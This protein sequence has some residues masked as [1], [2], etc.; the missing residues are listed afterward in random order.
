MSASWKTAGI[1][2]GVAVASGALFLWLGA[3]LERFINRVERVSH[4][5]PSRQAMAFHRS[6]F[7]ADLHADS[8][9]FERNLLER[10]DVGHVDVPRLQ[11]GGGAAAAEDAPE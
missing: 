8:L 2:L 5:E 11:E 7:V 10:S 1:A 4:P 3:N 9:T 6:S